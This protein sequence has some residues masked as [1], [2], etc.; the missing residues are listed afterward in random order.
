MKAYG[1]VEAQLHTFLKLELGGGKQSASHPQ[2]TMD[3]N[4][5]SQRCYI[6][7]MKTGSQKITEI[8]QLF[9]VWIIKIRRGYIYI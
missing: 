7:V 4:K 1:G 8:Q 6:N 3:I 5:K 2:K 9:Q